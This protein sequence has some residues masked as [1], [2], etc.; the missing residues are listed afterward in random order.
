MPPPTLTLADSVAAAGED[1]GSRGCEIRSGGDW[2]GAWHGPSIPTGRDVV[3]MWIV[4]DL[5]QRRD[6]GL[7]TVFCAM[8]E[9]D[10]EPV[11]A[12]EVWI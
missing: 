5:A 6:S 12:A 10:N 8:T 7:F 4:E 9:S 1:K 2:D 3:E 11:D